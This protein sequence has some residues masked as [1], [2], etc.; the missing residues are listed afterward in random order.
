MTNI[1]S[2]ILLILSVLIFIFGIDPIYLGDKKVKEDDKK[3]MKQVGIKDLK[4]TL[5]S[6]EDA[7]RNLQNIREARIKINESLGV[8]KANKSLYNTLLRMLPNEMESAKLIYIID[9]IQV[10]SHSYQPISDIKLEK[11]DRKSRKKKNGAI[12]IQ[13]A[14]NYKSVKMSFKFTSDYKNF[15]NFLDDL[16]HSDRLIDVVSVRANRD[17]DSK[18]TIVDKMV[19]D[20]TIRTY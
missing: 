12:D 1:L 15:I 19:Y 17:S 14:K 2:I 11:T 7:K 10:K 4:K 16:Y 13:E 3:E 9:S 8:V 18:E 20:F 5:A 6:L